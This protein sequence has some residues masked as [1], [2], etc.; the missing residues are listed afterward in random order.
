MALSPSQ[1]SAADDDDKDKCE[2]LEW[3]EPSPQRSWLRITVM[4]GKTFDMMLD[5]PLRYQFGEKL[6]LQ[7][8]AHGKT[9]KEYSVV[10]IKEYWTIQDYHKHIPGCGNPKHHVQQFIHHITVSPSA[11]IDRGKPSE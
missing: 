5:A 7:G 2:G 1:L 9:G 11:S 4:G 3:P 10:G 8:T 6:T